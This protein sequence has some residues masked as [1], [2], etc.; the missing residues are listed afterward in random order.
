MGSVGRHWRWPCCRVTL[1]GPLL[2]V[3]TCAVRVA[4]HVQPLAAVGDE[5]ELKMQRG[6]RRA[7]EQ[8]GCLGGGGDA[9]EA[10]DERYR[11]GEV[12][13]VLLLGQVEIADPT[14]DRLPACAGGLE[15]DAF[16]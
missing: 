5:A 8:S 12:G 13:G 9:G 1:R 16:L 7:E 3:S 6:G 4:F 14:A 15:R 2:L 11:R 10:G